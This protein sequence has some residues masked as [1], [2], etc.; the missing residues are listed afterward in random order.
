VRGRINGKVAL[1]GNDRL[2]REA[3]VSTQALE[4]EA[5]RLRELGQTVVFLG[6]DQR[7]VGLISVADPI[8]STTAEAI[9]QLRASGLRIIVLTGDSAAT[10]AAVAK[11]LGLDEVKAEVMP[12]DKYQHVQ[13]LQKEGRIVAMAGDG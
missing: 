13:E 11:Q 1:L 6:V 9:A 4:A 10:A 7:L 3:G 5:Q 8:K 2:M 12:A